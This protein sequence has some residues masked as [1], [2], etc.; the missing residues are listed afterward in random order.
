MFILY[1]LSMK[2]G[3]FFFKNMIS[4]LCFFLISG[5]S[6]SES[7]KETPPINVPFLTSIAGSSISIKTTDLPLLVES[8]L[9]YT[10]DGNLIADGT[11]FNLTST[12]VTLAPNLNSSSWS[13]Q[14]TVSSQNGKFKFYVKP[15]TIAGLYR[16]NAVPVA[17]SNIQFDQ[18][19]NARFFINVLPGN[20][21]SIG[22]IKTD[23]FEDKN[24][25]NNLK[26]SL[27][28][29]ILSANPD[30]ISYISVGPIKDQYDNLLSEGSIGLSVNSGSILSENPGRIIS[31]YAY[32]AYKSDGLVSNLPVQASLFHPSNINF[33]LNSTLKKASPQLAYSRSADFSNMIIGSSKC[34]VLNLTNNGAM[35]A[36]NLDLYATFPFNLVGENVNDP[37]CNLTTDV[38]KQNQT[39]R[40]GESCKVRVKFQMPVTGSSSGDLVAQMSPNEFSGALVIQRLRTDAI[41]EAK[42]VTTNSFVSFGG[43]QCSTNRVVD[44]VVENIGDFDA[45]NISV[46]N[47][48]PNLNQTNSF[49]S[50]ILP[51]QDA[52]LNPNMN[53][54]VNCGTTFPA[55]RKCRVQISF[56]P[57]AGI[58]NQALLG[59][60]VGD[61]INPLIITVSG[62][63]IPGQG[64][65]TF[66][67]T[68]NPPTNIIP[69]GMGLN[70]SQ[71][72]RVEIGPI[73]DA[74]NQKVADGS[75]VTASV[76]A[77]TL[78][79]S[80]FVTNNGSATVLWNA[81]NDIFKLGT[82]TINISLGAGGSKNASLLFKGVNLGFTG[83]SNFGQVIQGFP[84]TI[85]LTLTNN[86]NI[87]ASNLSF[88]TSSP[89]IITNTGTCASGS[90]NVGAS[91]QIT[92]VADPQNIN[93]D[94]TVNVT[95]NSSSFGSNNITYP[96]SLNARTKPVL[97]F[98]KPVYLF[99][100]GINSAYYEQT[101]LLTNSSLAFSYNTVLNIDAPYIIQSTTCTSTINPNSSCSIT[102]R[103]NASDISS[104]VGKTLSVSNEVDTNTPVANF[105]FS[106][107][108]FTNNNIRTII[109]RCAGPFNFS[110]EGSS[111]TIIPNTNIIA[112]VSSLFGGV[113]YSSSNCSSGTEITTVSLL[114]GNSQS[115]S[116]YVKIPNTGSDLI[117]ISDP[118]N[119]ISS[120]FQNVEVKPEINLTLPSPNAL[121]NNEEFLLTATGGYENFTY[122]FT[123]GSSTSSNANIVDI[124]DPNNGDLLG[125]KLQVLNQ[126][127]VNSKI[128]RVTDS[129]G[130]F[131]DFTFNLYPEIT[132]ISNLSLQT[133]DPTSILSNFNDYGNPNS[134][135]YTIQ[136]FNGSSY[137]NGSL[138]GSTIDSS[139]NYTY[140]ATSPSTASEF[141]LIQVAKTT[142]GFSTTRIS[143]SVTLAWPFGTLGDLTINS[144]QTVYL[145][146][147][148]TY[149]YRN[150]TINSGGAL[151]I[152]NPNQNA[153]SSYLLTTIGVSGNLIIDGT[154][155]APRFNPTWWN[156]YTWGVN[157]NIPRNSLSDFYTVSTTFI[158]RNG[159]NGG[160][161]YG[162]SGGAGVYGNGGGGGGQEG[163]SG[164]AASF[165][166]GGTGGNGRPCGVMGIGGTGGTVTS[167]N[168]NSGTYGYNCY[169]GY[170]AGG[171][172]GFRGLHSGPLAFK[173]K[174]SISGTGLIYAQGG[175]GGAGGSGGAGAYY[176]PSGGSGA[177][178]M[179]SPIWFYLKNSF[180]NYSNIFSFNITNP[181][182]ITINCQGGSAGGLLGSGVGSVGSGGDT[183]SPQVINF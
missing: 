141:I 84:K 15:Y 173:V 36:S 4:I 65:N 109:N 138:Y 50:I 98:D 17:N 146:Y 16:V 179:G 88:S 158:Q 178:G 122:T 152:S 125:R 149:D 92:V 129:L 75:I 80:T 64:L 13:E 76:T 150:I 78:S 9:I 135:T 111:S 176:G 20:P 14:L 6:P 32:F 46:V 102:V 37:L 54:I 26:D 119:L 52:V 90:L 47:P 147:G 21:S 140:T 91:C 167:P 163:Y 171:G 11:N 108:K 166:Q 157:F 144:G 2:S 180:S 133:N 153:T 28:N 48:P 57:T 120:Q 181:S 29:W 38:C 66:P 62:Y 161:G 61:N 130:F 55:K 128:V 40:S 155:Y 8:S 96:L 45:T 89:L 69:L 86:G 136:N 103:L 182:K 154:F 105:G 100:S 145:T 126:T 59:K 73:V 175:N 97:A 164:G 51:P 22:E 127:V 49:Y 177:G 5:C 27:E 30:T 183:C 71:Q 10:D 72:T 118:N 82:Q 53:S 131:K 67:L 23:Q 74:C 156:G 143:V 132:S 68:L 18:G 113:F 162:T 165:S 148:Q 110:L 172:G 107:F 63:T 112:N 42:L 44:I 169:G 95:A 151:V 117:T 123:D 41:A 60:I 101:L 142:G 104:A 79:S 12:S 56:N 81:V 174:G 116:F 35:P 121:V 3:L 25:Y 33:N 137:I 87:D 168:G 7:K 85:N 159:G 58:T 93:Q 34:E 43:T 24:P 139:G 160:S 99:N 94:L 77:G 1:L 124:T 83:N 106:S 115:N 114:S 70:N 39:L 19:L 170:G 31:G 134:K